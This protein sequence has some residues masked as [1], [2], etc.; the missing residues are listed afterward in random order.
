MQASTV[1]RRSGR[2]S[3]AAN[4]TMQIQANLRVKEGSMEG[5]RRLSKGQKLARE[6]RQSR[7]QLGHIVDPAKSLDTL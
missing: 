5:Q 2:E 7:H 4:K 3:S 6:P 1:A